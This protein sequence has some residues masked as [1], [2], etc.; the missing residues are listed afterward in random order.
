M[1]D[2]AKVKE[3]YAGTT[4]C[5]FN[6]PLVKLENTSDLSS[7]AFACRFESDTGYHLN[8]GGLMR[9]KR[10]TRTKDGTWWLQ[11]P[12]SYWYMPQATDHWY[13]DSCKEL[14]QFLIHKYPRLYADN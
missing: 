5:T 6:A 12:T 7:D 14:I 2:A 11:I 1:G 4:V 10:I 8:I 13:F 9:K 3:S